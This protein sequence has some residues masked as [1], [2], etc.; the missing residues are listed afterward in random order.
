MIEFGDITK[1]IILTSDTE[2]SSLSVEVWL[3]RSTRVSLFRTK[4]RG[5]WLV[6]SDISECKPSVIIS[7]KNN[8]DLV[9]KLKERNFHKDNA[10][11]ANNTENPMRYTLGNQNS[12]LLS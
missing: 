6:C 12:L 4:Y 3:R 5:L 1:T 8:S 9:A 11:M 2:L 7:T 10:Y